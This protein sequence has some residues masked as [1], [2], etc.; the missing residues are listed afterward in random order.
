VLFNIQILRAIA[1]LM[2]V[3]G[4][5][6]RGGLGLSFVAGGMVG[7]DLFFVISGF[8]IAYVATIDSSQFMMRRVI[9]IVPIYW[10]STLALYV[11]VVVAPQLFRTTSDDPRLLA[12]SLVFIPDP[13]GV[14]TADGVPHPTLSGGWTLNFEMYF[15]AVFWVALSISKQ[16]A[17]V[18]AT[19]MLTTVI[20]FMNV[21]GLSEASEVAHFYG[22]PIIFE[23]MY[24]MLAYHL[25]RYAETH[26]WRDLWPDGQRK[27]LVAIVAA[28]LGVLMYSREMTHLAPR[29]FV[30]GIPAFFVV[31]GA[32]LLEKLHDLK[33]TNRYAVMIGDASYV[34][35]LIHSYIIYGVTRL[36]IGK[37]EIWE[38]LGQVIV[39]GLMAVCC[40]A[41]ILVYRYIEQPILRVLKKRL[42][43]RRARPA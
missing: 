13:I 20:V 37:I 31:T 16:W 22:Y 25:V 18:L 36:V 26:G 8:I 17:T 19:V 2:V 42:I 14:H 12:L 23:F 5:A 40:V 43:K 11:L 24:G 9:R 7:V 28:G 3:H 30:S 1:A 35:Y 32:V 34:L 4:H 29:W 6:A 21:S 33:I 39:L 27:L 10:V 38:P 41:A 15:Y